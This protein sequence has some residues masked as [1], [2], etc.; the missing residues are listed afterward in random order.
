MS[1]ATLPVPTDQ[2]RAV[3]RQEQ[4]K[5]EVTRQQEQWMAPPVDIYETADGLMV[6]ADLPGVAKENLN[7]EVKNDL[8][9]IQ[10]KPN[11]S[12]SGSPVYQEFQLGNLY[13]QFR[14]TDAVNTARIEAE[15]KYGVLMLRLPKAEEAK[16]RKIEVQ[17]S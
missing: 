1:N 11:V 4:G 17:V 2:N 9:T 12:N 15:L 6:V 10:A 16:P 7:I 8:L 3:T 14:L 5:Q 13:R